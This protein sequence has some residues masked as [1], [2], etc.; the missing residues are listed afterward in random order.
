MLFISDRLLVGWWW[1]WAAPRSARR[2]PRAAPGTRRRPGGAGGPRAI[3]CAPGSVRAGARALSARA[4][5]TWASPPF[6]A[7]HHPDQTRSDRGERSEPRAWTR[8][9]ERRH[10]AETRTVG[11]SGPG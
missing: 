10:I 4:S 2:G 1:I 11:R 9:R 7:G 8:R 6:R 5:G 3:P